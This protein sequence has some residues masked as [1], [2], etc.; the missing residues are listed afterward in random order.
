MPKDRYY[1]DLPDFR[2]KVIPSK[3]VRVKDY[4]VP[5]PKEELGKNRFDKVLKRSK[6]R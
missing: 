5:N 1:D 3:K 4:N 2:I 6:E